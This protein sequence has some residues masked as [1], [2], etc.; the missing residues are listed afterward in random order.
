MKGIIKFNGKLYQPL[1]EGSYTIQ[2]KIIEVDES[3]YQRMWKRVKQIRAEGCLL[4]SEDL[5]EIEK[6]ALNDNHITT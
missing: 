2:G 1:E 3:K 6:Q 4:T 5:E